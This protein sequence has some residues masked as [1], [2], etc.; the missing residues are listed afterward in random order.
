MQ[1][2]SHEA[3]LYFWDGIRKIDMVLAFVDVEK[4]DDNNEEYERILE[5]RE[6]FVRNL[7]KQGLE[8]ELEPSKVSTVANKTFRT[9]A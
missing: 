3:T 9:E 8:L 4:D 6:T 5:K 1:E 7:E 2:K